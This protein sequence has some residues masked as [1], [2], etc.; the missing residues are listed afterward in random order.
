[1]EGGGREPVVMG[2]LTPMSNSR[3]APEASSANAR[4][5]MLANRR[6]D[7]AP[8]MALRRELHRR[9]FRYRVDYAPVP[10]LR[11]RADIVFTKP[12]VAVFVD[13]CFWH[14]CPEHGNLPMANRDWWRAKLDGNVVRDRRNDQTLFTAGWRVIR[15]WEHVPIADAA[16]RVSALLEPSP[17]SV[18]G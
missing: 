6:R 14:A 13:G 4:A 15:I 12:R 16:D 3:R 2:M 11:C 18:S 7:T 5:T 10:G 17:V 1:M 8:E 9:G